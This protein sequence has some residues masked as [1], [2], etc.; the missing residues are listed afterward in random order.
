MEV[1]ILLPV[2]FKGY[3]YSRAFSFND[4]YVIKVVAL[5]LP[6]MLGS[7]V[8]QLNVLIDRMLASGLSEGSIS[9]LNFANRL[10]GFVYG[11]F[12]CLYPW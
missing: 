10:N 3:R 1:A 8:Q 11:L 5:A 4:P 12:P 6:V 7:A 2:V 9:A